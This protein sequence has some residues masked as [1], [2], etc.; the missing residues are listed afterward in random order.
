MAGLW[1]GE[2]VEDGAD[3]KAMQVFVFKD[4]A[5]GSTAS[6]SSLARR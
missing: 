2:V 1:G 4:G 5:D 3:S 6:S